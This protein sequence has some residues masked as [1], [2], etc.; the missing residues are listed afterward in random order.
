MVPGLD[1]HEEW[2]EE[3]PANLKTTYKT[4][5]EQIKKDQDLRAAGSMY[6]CIPH[7]EPHQHVDMTEG[8]DMLWRGRRDREQDDSPVKDNTDKYGKE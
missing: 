8:S 7:N 2:E 5:Q 1:P 4:V 6:T 3:L